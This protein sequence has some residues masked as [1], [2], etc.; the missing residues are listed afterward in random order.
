MRDYL[1]GEGVDP[2][3]ITIV[4]FEGEV[5]RVPVAIANPQPSVPAKNSCHILFVGRVTYD[6]GLQYLL[7]G[8]T[9][10][11]A[12]FTL[13][14]AGDGWYLPTARQLAR[15]FGLSERTRFLGSLT[16]TD[17]DG[18]YRGA[19]IVV[20]PSIL[21]EPLGLVVGE[22]RGHGLPVVVT[23]AGG[24]PEW[25]NGDAG[26]VIAP[27]ANASALASALKSLRARPKVDRPMALR[28]TPSLC[29]AII[30]AMPDQT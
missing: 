29:D 10:L 23:D 27:R 11:D 30:A 5:N 4:D 7:E 17:L 14:V 1:A 24:L 2:D 26:V 28:L 18:V 25:A 22:A 6:K 21:P 8:L 20:V 13:E 16:R 12:S 3:R 19:D 9:Q 15:K